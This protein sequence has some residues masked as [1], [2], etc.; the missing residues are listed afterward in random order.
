[1]DKETSKLLENVSDELIT[2]F[3]D[4]VNDNN[5]FVF[6]FYSNRNGKNQWNPIC[7]CMDWIS[8]AIRSIQNSPI[9]SANIDVKVM[10][11]YALIS[12]IDIVNESIT[13]LHS[14]FNGEKGRVSPFKGAKGCFSNS[15]AFVDDDTHFKEIRAKFGAHPVNLDGDSGERLFASWPHDAFDDEFDIQV[16]LYSNIVGKEDQTFG[17]RLEELLNFLNSRYSYLDT[18]ISEINNQYSSFCVEMQKTPIAT[19]TDTIK[20]LN[21]LEA[22]SSERLDNDY[23]RSIILDLKMVFGSE[24]GLDHLVEKEASY[25]ES[26]QQ[27]LKEVLTNL[28]TMNLVDL[29]HDTTRSR[30]S[31]ERDLSYELPK[32]Y[33]WIY[34]GRTDPLLDYYMRR[35]NEFS[36][37]EYEFSATDGSAKTFLKLKIFLNSL[38]EAD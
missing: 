14:I 27:L 12:S 24:T 20:Q 32:L 18:L 31:I 26:Q 36:G 11:I 21:I 17:I 16:R 15:L 6:S 38:T 3:R 22:A 30:T 37:G 5:M 2:R 13:S 7:S 34:S 33:S 29:E 8:V 25:K 10:Q 1:M 35:L 4:V 19:S 9:F 23:Y 28:Q